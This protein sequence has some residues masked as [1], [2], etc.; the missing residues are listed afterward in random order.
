[1]F[2]LNGK[3][4][5]VADGSSAAAEAV[6]YGLSVAGATVVVVTSDKTKTQPVL[7]DLA[8]HS[9]KAEMI[10]MEHTDAEVVY[11]LL[12]E[13]VNRYDKIDLLVNLVHL[14]EEA[15]ID[16]ISDENWK[17]LMQTNTTGAFLYCRGVI[18]YM[19]RQK[20]GKIINVVS[21]DGKSGFFHAGVHASAAS[22]AVLSM[23]R[24]LAKQEAE[25]GIR[26]NAVAC[27]ALENDKTQPR[28]REEI[29]KIPAGRLAKPEDVAGAVVF[30]A[31]DSADFI[32]GETIDVNGGFYMA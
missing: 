21:V 24:Q 11:S 13:A 15:A 26:V 20:F 28:A 14:S 9:Y 31:S 22:G 23:T 10:C 16:G 1:M 17:G 4:A 32:T 18:P 2:N 30:L 25:G 5:I 6:I 7:D 29:S 19:R 8:D 3:V 12:E 27:G